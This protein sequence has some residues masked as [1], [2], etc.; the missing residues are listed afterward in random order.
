M[1]PKELFAI[2]T[3]ELTRGRHDAPL[4]IM[5]AGP[6]GAGKSTAF[7]NLI[8]TLAQ[9]MPWDF[10]NAD[11]MVREM[12][13]DQYGSGVHLSA[14]PQHELKALQLQAQ[15]QMHAERRTRIEA[16]RKMDFVFETVFSDPYGHRLAELDKAR[17][18]GFCTVM[19]AVCSDDLEALITRVRARE[20]RG[21]HGV[22]EATQRQ[23]YP[24][25]RENL[26]TAASRVSLAFLLDNSRPSDIA[27]KGRY[28]PVAVIAHGQLLGCVNDMPEWAREVVTALAPHNGRPH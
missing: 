16:S 5:L 11:E 17:E 15:R 4:S 21:G 24:R 23:R 26:C 13:D 1:T 3:S 25:V 18:A 8:G 7:L 22:D 12:V 20:V 9:D 28:R 19:V 14:L 10:L 2:F 27:G 6:N